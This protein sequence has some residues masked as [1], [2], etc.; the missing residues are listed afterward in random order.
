MIPPINPESASISEVIQQGRKQMLKTDRTTF[1]RA[2]ERGSHDRDLINSILDASPLCHVG[3]N[4]GD[5]PVVMPT[6]HWRVDDRVYWHGSRISR[7]MLESD[8]APMCLTVTMLDG[9]VLARSAFHHSANYRSVLVFGQPALVTDEDEKV[10]LLKRF[11]DGLCP[12]RWDALRPVTDKEMNATSVLSLPITE[13]SAK[14]RDGGPNDLDED[15]AWPVWA[16]VVPLTSRT[17]E[18]ETAADMQVDLPV[19][20]HASGYRMG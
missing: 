4:V 15:L 3:Y 20:D 6:C 17:G 16:G 10:Y 1:N 5:H 11:V 14:V 2:R 7:T 8:S 18:P 12:G 13:A 9:L 19:P